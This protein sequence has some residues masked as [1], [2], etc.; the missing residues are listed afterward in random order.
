MPPS[1]TNWWRLEAHARDPLLAD[2]LE[3][4][5]ADPLWMLG[6]QWQTGEFLG[7]DG[8]TPVNARARISVRTLGWYR[9]G[10]P[11]RTALGQPLDL[12]AAPLELLV[13]C[14]PAPEDLRLA[15]AGGRQWLRL[16]RAGSGVLANWLNAGFAIDPDVAGRAPDIDAERLS[17]ATGGRALDGRAV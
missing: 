4:R 12:A 13:E 11:R 14:E 7:T 2:A 9:T 8:G 3:A 16:L 5:I 6:R 15:I 10:G 17:A 1:V